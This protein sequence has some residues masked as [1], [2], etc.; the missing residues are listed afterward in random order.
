MDYRDWLRRGRMKAREGRRKVPSWMR[1]T[2]QRYSVLVLCL[3]EEGNTWQQQ[4]Q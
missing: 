2:G 3:L 1:E 4:K